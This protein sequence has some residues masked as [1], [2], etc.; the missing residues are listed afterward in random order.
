ME[1]SR[2]VD[3]GMTSLTLLSIEMGSNCVGRSIS[4]VCSKYLVHLF[5]FLLLS[6]LPVL[7]Q[8]FLHL[9]FILTLVS[10]YGGYDAR[11]LQKVHW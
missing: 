1:E 3:G 7:H 4:R 8:R 9:A 2:L 6:L 10:A 5:C 11:G